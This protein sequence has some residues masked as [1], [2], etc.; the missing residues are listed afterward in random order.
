MDI[1]IELE[2]EK[3]CYYLYNERDWYLNYYL[4]FIMNS[5]SLFLIEGSIIYALIIK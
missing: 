2:Y 3:S 4:C 5:L 1:I